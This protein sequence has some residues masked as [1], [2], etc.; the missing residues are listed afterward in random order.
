METASSE[1]AAAGG[2]SETRLE[3]DRALVRSALAG[4]ASALARF[5]AVLRD[6]ASTAL[7]SFR[8]DAMALE[9][10]T[11]AVRARLL[12]GSAGEGR[13]LEQY[14]GT[15]PL[16][17]WLRAVL[18]RAALNARRA[19]GVDVALEDIAEPLAGAASPE[20]AL[21]RSRH[22]PAM[23][24]A[25]VEALATLTTRE[26]TLL[27]LTGLD[28]LTLAELGVIYG[29]DA[30]TVSRW[31]SAARAQTLRETRRAL[32]AALKLDADELDSFVRDVEAS[33]FAS[34]SSLLREATGPAPE[35][36]QGIESPGVGV[37]K[38]NS[39]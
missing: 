9:E 32:A 7:A 18:V 12:V 6:E 19:Q 33:L 13:R 1:V 36:V 22:R 30:S 24:A 15:G 29:K 38:G 35:T 14:A 26:R 20:L 10:L 17:A 8:L 31:L 3:R 37:A 34:L 16:G 27:R 25:V 4:E 21:L 23:R 5:D 2:P 39:P 28:G 11:Q